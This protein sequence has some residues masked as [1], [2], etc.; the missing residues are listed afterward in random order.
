MTE[1]PPFDEALSQ[2]LRFIQD[3]GFSTDLVWAFREDVTSCGRTCWVRAPIPAGNEELAR[4]DYER[5]RRAGFGVTMAV[6][7]RLEGRSVC[8]VW[9]PE[10]EIAAEYAMQGPLKIAVPVQPT[11]AISVRS[12]LVWLWLR[13]RNRWRQCDHF[14]GCLPSREEVTAIHPEQLQISTQ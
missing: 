6:F 5:G 1:T 11:D 14:S 7:C 2:F 10:D 13:L 8:Y 12:G 9:A 3:T 4:R